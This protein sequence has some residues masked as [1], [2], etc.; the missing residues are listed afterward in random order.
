RDSIDVAGIDLYP[1][2]HKRRSIIGYLRQWWEAARLPLFLSEFGTPE[3]YN[4]KTRKDT[5][6]FIEAGIDSHRI[7]QARLLRRALEQA[8]R[9]GIP[10]PYGGWYPGTGNI[11]WGCSLTQDRIKFDCDR[12]GLVDLARQPDG[13]LK[14]VLCSGLVEE[15]LGLRTIYAPERPSVVLD[16]AEKPAA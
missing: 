12:A 8:E 1:H 13:T 7:A 9:E 6:R 4:P 11:G 3:S 5:P 10:I 2:M 14:R 16:P 15:I